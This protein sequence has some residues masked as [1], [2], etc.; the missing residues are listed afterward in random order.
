MRF[1]D[2]DSPTWN[3]KRWGMF[4]P[5]AEMRWARGKRCDES[6]FDLY[7][8]EK[9][10]DSPQI[11]DNICRWPKITF[12]NKLRTIIIESPRLYIIPFP[13]LLSL[14]M[15]LVSFLQYRV[16]S[17]KLI[18]SFVGLT[19]NLLK[20]LILRWGHWENWKK[21]SFFIVTLSFKLY[22]KTFKCIR[23]NVIHLL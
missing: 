9:L 11:C 20:R 3:P 6:F 4:L 5:A 17:V 8:T 22:M 23:S 12:A 21:A 13:S 7:F 2:W 18:S 15:S 14:N 19:Y 10:Q 16:H 1:K